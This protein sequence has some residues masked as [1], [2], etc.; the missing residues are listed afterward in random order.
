MRHRMVILLLALLTTPAFADNGPV[1]QDLETIRSAATQFLKAQPHDTGI[2]TDIQAGNLD[3]RLRLPRC[4]QKLQAFQPAGARSVGNTTVGVRCTS[5]ATWSIYVPMHVS[6]S[7]A[8]MIV[9]RPIPRGAILHA[10]DLRSERRDLAALSYGYVL[11]A[12]QADGQRVTR[13]LSEG[14]VLTP[15]VLAAPKWVKRGEHVTVLAKSSGMEIRM[16]GEALMDGTEGAVVRVRNINSARV[17]EG[18]VIAQGV[19]QV[20]L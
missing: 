19:I 5:G 1:L 8:V 3:S 17:I 7:A 18:T 20:R 4:E 11:H 6:A 10:A 15:N 9:N 13:S 16:T 12:K 2:S 14:T